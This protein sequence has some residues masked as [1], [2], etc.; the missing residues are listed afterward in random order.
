MT[1]EEIYKRVH[2]VNGIGGMTVNERLFAAKL[3]DTFY[4][5]KKNNTDLAKKILTALEVDQN[6][7]EIILKK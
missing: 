5:A 4:K 3:L 6:S 2:K 1:D 7:I